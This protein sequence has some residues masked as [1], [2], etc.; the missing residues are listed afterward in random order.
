MDAVLE[1]LFPSFLLLFSHVNIVKLRELRSL[2]LVEA[3]FLTCSRSGIEVTKCQITSK[4]PLGWLL[5]KCFYGGAW[6][7]SSL[8]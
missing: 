6:L 5:K 2:M 3:L 4:M 7:T 1:R 8:D